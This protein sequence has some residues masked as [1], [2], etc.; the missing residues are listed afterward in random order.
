[1]VVR[2]LEQ[3]KVIQQVFSNDRKTLHL[4]PSWQDIDLLESLDKTLSP[5]ADLTDI[6]SWEKYVTMSSMA[7]DIPIHNKGD[8]QRTKVSRRFQHIYRR[9]GGE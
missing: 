3:E 5:F 7:S 2:L 6:L 8:T 4:I 1:M 9:H